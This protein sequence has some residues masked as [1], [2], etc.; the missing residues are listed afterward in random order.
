M[1][2]HNRIDVHHHFLPDFY[3][4]A[5]QDAGVTNSGGQLFTSWTPQKSLM[6]MQES[7]STTAIV[8]ISEPG[9]YPI[10]YRNKQAARDLARKINEYTADLHEKY[11]QQFG[12]YA[13][14][15]LPDM[16]GSLI[17]LEYALDDLKLDG[18]AL[19]SNYGTH[20]L[21]DSR[22]NAL[23][24]AINERNGVFH[25]HPSVPP[26][27]LSRPE[28]MPIDFMQEF[29]F[30]TTRAAVNLIFSGTLE[31]CQNLKPI[32]AHMGGTLPYL[33][34][35][36]DDCFEE[37]GKHDISKLPLP[38]AVLDAWMSIPGRIA[39]QMRRFYFDTA[40]AADPICFAAVD[41]VAP[42]HMLSGTD[43]FFALRTQGIRFAE[44]VE[45]YY[46]DEDKLYAVARGNA[47]GLFP[48]FKKTDTK[49]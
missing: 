3:L 6:L 33:R 24:D 5:L 30:N 4:K 14:L 46:T 47:E 49:L 38:P 21:G 26:S 1:K 31:R 11:P 36:L 2:V 18:V 44:N 35:R 27:E 10:T 12:G 34:F 7:G 37:L 45:H 43:A 22:F 17:E 8:S 28:F 41:A 48:R 40:L 19:L 13:V 15:P 25:V 16:E 42:G 20:F 9:L 23:F 29:T 39:N 32:L